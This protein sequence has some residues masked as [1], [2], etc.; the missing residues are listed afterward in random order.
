MRLKDLKLID[1]GILIFDDVN[2]FDIVGPM[3]VFNAAQIQN[4]DLKY[5]N[6]LDNIYNTISLFNTKLISIYPKKIITTNN[7]SKII[8]DYS[9]NDLEETKEIVSFN[10]F[11]WVIPGGKGVHKIREDNNFIKWLKIAIENAHIS[12]SV[13]TG[14]Y[15]VAQTKHLDTETVATHWRHFELFSK[16]FPHI[17][18]DVNARYVEANKIVTT[19]GG[20]CSIDGALQVVSLLV[21]EETAQRVADMIVHPWIG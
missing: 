5:K 20:S 19:G 16:E 11:I 10:P 1:V 21:S 17:D 2:F 14:V 8:P 13:C 9:L 3:E 15:A 12:L 7:G 6:E 18:I 4:E